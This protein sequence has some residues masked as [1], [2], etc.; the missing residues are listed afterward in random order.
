MT[1]TT[2]TATLVSAGPPVV[3]KHEGVVP[4]HDYKVNVG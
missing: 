1:T 2:P 4:K 3:S